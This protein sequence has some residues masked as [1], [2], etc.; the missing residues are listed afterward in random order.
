MQIEKDAFIKALAGSILCPSD[1]KIE[2]EKKDKV[3][4]FS[5]DCKRCW[6]EALNGVSNFE[7][8]GGIEGCRK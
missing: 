7:L 1:M 3:C 5:L 8:I 4:G 6:N 2:V